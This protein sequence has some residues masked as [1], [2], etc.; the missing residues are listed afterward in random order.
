M[1]AGFFY[2]NAEQ[3]EKMVAAER[4]FVD[5]RVQKIIDLKR[6]VSCD[7][8]LGFVSVHSAASALL[9]VCG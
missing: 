7:P 6:K 9:T 8:D 4:K 1:N 2:N 3:R 5:E